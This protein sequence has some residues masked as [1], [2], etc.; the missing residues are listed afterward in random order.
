M[1]ELYGAYYGS[2]ASPARF[3]RAV[4]TIAESNVHADSSQSLRYNPSIQ[5]DAEI[6]D[7]YSYSMSDRYPQILT[8]ILV[9]EAFPAARSL[10]GV[11][12]HSLQKFYAHSTWVEQGNTNIL[13][14]LGLPGFPGFDD[15]AQP[16]EDV[17]TPCPA[18]QGECRDNV[19]A[20]AGLTTGFYTYKEE[21][22]VDY[23]VPKP[24]T[25][26]KCSHGGVL[27]DTAG[28]TPIGGINKDT[29]S[30]CFSPHYYLHDK[31]AELA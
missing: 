3:I 19:V 13:P 18:A 28:E 23:L 25:G 29:A 24:A 16:D 31:A 30:P 2:S 17:C 21:L 27:D 6:F 8:A 4:N 15:P 26:G 12:L 1:T 20:G 5:A 11:T 14:D 22:A 10:L 7:E 9:D